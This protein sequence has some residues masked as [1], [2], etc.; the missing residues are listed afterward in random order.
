MKGNN[1]GEEFVERRKNNN[2]TA[3]PIPPLTFKQS[4][5]YIFMT[6]TLLMSDACSMLLAYSIAFWLRV[7][8]VGDFTFLQLWNVIPI[9]VFFLVMYAWH[10]LYPGI[11][12]SPVSEMKQLFSATNIVFLILIATTFWVKTPMN[13]SR[14]MLAMTWLLVLILVQ[15]ARWLVR[16]I[17]RK[18]GF[19]G[20]PVA[21]VGN[22]PQVKQIVKFLNERL[23]LGMLPVLVVDGNIPYEK[24]ALASINHSNIS[25]VILVTSE[26]SE[27]LQTSF[28]NDQRYGYHRR[29]GEKSINRLILISDIDCVGSLGIT[30]YDL[31]GM[32]GLE[33]RQNLLD[34]WP[35]FLK[36]LIDL[37][38]TAIFGILSAPFLLVIMAL[39]CLDSP[40]G[41]FY[42]QDRVGRNGRLFKMWKFRTM[43]ANADQVL[44][45]CLADDPQLKSEWDETQKLK[46]DP[47][48]TRV[49]K[50]LRKF[51]LDEI[52]QLINVCKGEM[53]L[54]G[55]RPYFP[56]QQKIYGNGVK[57]YQRVRP[58]MTGMWQVRGR[59]TTSFSER[60]RLDEYYVRNWSVWLDI[61]IILRTILVVASNEGAY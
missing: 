31:D 59:N 40:G 25:T 37:T 44:A 48:I 18:L 38:L 60:A 26:M 13:F 20:E 5:A 41:A 39:I 57:L 19:W 8:M 14:F 1:W 42:K 55:P 3:K 35:N 15:A 34:K 2:T 54:V 47:R 61:Y 6:I 4:Y 7:I 49:G 36:R 56:N 46:N 30:P 24:S 58:G 27:E 9:M 29:R 11:G 23:R 53:S 51:S 33:V 45:K 28:V 32:L 22:G 12:L 50:F 52:P 17:G 21:V 43:Q 10:G 16:I